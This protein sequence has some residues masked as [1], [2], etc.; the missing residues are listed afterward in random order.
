M[1][2]AARQRRTLSLCESIRSNDETL[3]EMHLDG[4]YYDSDMTSDEAGPYFRN[5]RQALESS[6]YNSSIQKIKIGERLVRDMPEQG[7]STLLEHLGYLQGLQH[8][9]ISLWKRCRIRALALANFFKRS[10]SIQS[11]VIWPMLS[12][13]NDGLNELNRAVRHHATLESFHLLN[14][15]TPG[16]QS[17]NYNPLFSLHSLIEALATVPHL[18]HL[19]LAPGFSVRPD[20]GLLAQVESSAPALKKLIES[21]SNLESLALRNVGLTNTDVEGLAQALQQQQKSHRCARRPNNNK[22][23]E[24]YSCLKHLDLRFNTRITELGYE[25]LVNMLA[26]SNYHLQY[27]DLD[28]NNSGKCMQL[29]QDVNFYLTLNRVGRF[30]FLNEDNNN[31]NVD[32]HAK[33]HHNQM[34]KANPTTTSIFV[35]RVQVLIECNRCELPH[36]AHSRR[37]RQEE[38]RLNLIYYLLRRNPSVTWETTTMT[39]Q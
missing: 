35:G 31:N 2:E 14:I 39:I 10:P 21:C 19:Q 34:Q 32:V 16:E 20:S 33:H 13:S 22:D 37:R 15:V 29:Q 26:N 25:M 1:I 18:R 17:T 38:E 12:I 36:I 8:L 9:E 23:Q 6:Q 5:V 4:E 3:K 27:L 24:Q 28:W 30:T 11:I 7:L